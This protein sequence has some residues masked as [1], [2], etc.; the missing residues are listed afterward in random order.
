MIGE[1]SLSSRGRDVRPP[2]LV[3]L[4][5]EYNAWYE[6]VGSLYDATLAT[7]A[8]AR[9]GGWAKGQALQWAASSVQAGLGFL[10]RLG[11]RRLRWTLDNK[12]LA[13]A[14]ASLRPYR[15]GSAEEPISDLYARL[16]KQIGAQVELE[17]VLGDDETIEEG[18]WRPNPD[19]LTSLL[20]S[21]VKLLKSP[22]ASAKW[23]ALLPLIED[24]GEEKIVFFAQP[25][26]TVSVVARFLEE[27]FGE[28]PSII[29]GDQS[30]YERHEQ[31]AAFQQDDGPRFLVSSRAGGEG[32][33]MQR[34]RRLIHLDVPWNPME[35]EQRIGR[36]H[37][38]GS[39]K[40]IVVD[41]IVAAG[42][43]EVQMYRSARDKLRLISKQLD[44]E[45]FESLFSRVMALVPPAELEDILS[46]APFVDS[47]ISQEIGELVRKGYEAWQSFDDKYRKNSE[48][49]QSLA[50][51][52]AT[53]TDLGKF[54]TRYGSALWSSDATRTVFD[55]DE[56]EIVA[57][58][59]LLRTINLDGQL[60]ACG[61]T[62]GLK[63]N[64][65][66]AQEIA[67]LGL[68]VAAVA[69]TSQGRVFSYALGWCCIRV[70]LDRLAAIYARRDIRDAV[71]SKTE[72]PFWRRPSN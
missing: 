52:E 43:R 48:E 20:I 1:E 30:E 45:Q 6:E 2:R 7:G 70:P 49:I 61:D 3:Q 44:P 66:G 22:A 32:L 42:S 56:G 51:G 31:V 36:V 8:R 27:K 62:G 63:L 64:H 34:A 21:G 33:N 40:T 69:K 26:E 35:L 18:S 10:V 38:F 17:D 29:I 28:R 13:T 47:D 59:E 37:R 53:W 71:F 39:R 16:K 72:S 15:K 12:A 24:A 68:N 55:F 25:V 67:Q 54:L 60:Y 11:I 5:G 41:T 57:V 9:A 4:G 65:A 19:A 58:D 50:G 46:N 14:I 23:E